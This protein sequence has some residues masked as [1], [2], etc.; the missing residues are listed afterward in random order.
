MGMDV[1]INVRS[2]RDG[3]VREAPVRRRVDVR[4]LF[5]IRLCLLVGGL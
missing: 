2:K 1:V 5:Q 3:T 4:S